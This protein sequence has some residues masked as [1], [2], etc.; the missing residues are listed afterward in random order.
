MTGMCALQGKRGGPPEIVYGSVVDYYA[1]A[2][3][4]AGVASAL[5]ERERSGEGQYVGVSLLRSALAM[6]SARLVWAEG[7]PRDV[8]RDMR[9]GGITGI[10]PTREGYLYISANTPHFWRALCEKVGLPELQPTSATTR[11]RKRAQHAAEIVPRLHAGAARAQRAR[12]GGA[13]SATRCRAR[14]RAQSRTCSTHPQV[15]AEDMVATFEH[16]TVGKLPRLHARDQVR[17]HAGARAFG[18]ARI[19]PAHR[20]RPGGGWLLKRGNCGNAPER[21][22]LVSLSGAPPS[23]SQ[24]EIAQIRSLSGSHVGPTG[25]A[26]AYFSPP[27][28]LFLFRYVDCLKK[29]L[30]N[31]LHWSR[32]YS[33]LQHQKSTSVDRDRP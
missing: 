2:L 16:P 24:L 3:V 12:M 27:N 32:C 10:H 33:S 19:W 25:S 7:E 31:Q 8:G 9:S 21:R 23:S 26:Q 17:P 22:G 6:Q 14:R 28:P 29:R 15:L 20:C 4:A 1:A 18:R 5:Y 11:V 13:S 30:R